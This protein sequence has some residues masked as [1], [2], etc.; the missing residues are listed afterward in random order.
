MFQA[1]TNAAI[2]IGTVAQTHAWTWN[3]DMLLASLSQ[4]D[5]PTAGT[6]VTDGTAWCSG[7]TV[8]L[9]NAGTDV[10]FSATLGLNGKTKCSWQLKTADGSKAP[11]FTAGALS[12]SKFQ[13]QWIEFL[14]ST[15]LGTG[16]VMPTSDGANYYVGAYTGNWLNPLTSQASGETNF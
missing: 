16:G 1:G 9:P 2:T 5:W 7:S 12:Y 3:Q 6:K 11:G 4:I 15:G 14:T 8:S 10:A 13:L